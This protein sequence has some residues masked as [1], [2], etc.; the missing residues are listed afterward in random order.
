[1][2]RY[3]TK[4]SEAGHSPCCRINPKFGALSLLPSAANGI[5]GH[6]GQDNLILPRRVSDPFWQP[7]RI[8]LPSQDA[9]RQLSVAHQPAALEEH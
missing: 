5:G 8:A 2:F 1:M 6:P 4:Q 9:S 3:V 7:C